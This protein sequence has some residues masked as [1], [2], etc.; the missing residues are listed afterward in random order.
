M[1]YGRDRIADMVL[2]H[3]WSFYD[4]VS[5]AAVSRGGQLYWGHAHYVAADM[6]M[7]EPAGWER[8]LRDAAICAGA[9]L[10]DLAVWCARDALAAGAP[11]E[12]ARALRAA[13]G[14]D[15]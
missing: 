15:R 8:R 3:T 5:E 2:G 14:D 12:A 10:A 13:L 4:G 1:H 6:A 11:P 7:R 9:G